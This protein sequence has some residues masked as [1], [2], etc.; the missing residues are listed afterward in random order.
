MHDKNLS[1]TILLQLNYSPTL[2]DVDGII[3]SSGVKADLD[4]LSNELQIDIGGDKLFDWDLDQFVDSGKYQINLKGS[5]K[6][7]FELGKLL[8]ALAKHP[9]EDKEYHVHIDDIKDE[10]DTPQ[11]HLIVRAPW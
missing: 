8:I 1:D 6:A 4:L 2:K 10:A 3:R 11:A 5:K 7:F 9:D